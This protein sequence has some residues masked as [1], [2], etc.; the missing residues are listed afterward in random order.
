[1]K[2]LAKPLEETVREL[3]TERQAEV[4]DLIEFLLAKQRSRQRRKPQF[5]WAGALKAMPD[6]YTS[7][8]LQH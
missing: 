5:D 1:M 7:V 6:D 3:S 8:D 2:E 4:R